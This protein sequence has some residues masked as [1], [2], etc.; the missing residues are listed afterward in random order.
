M[1]NPLWPSPK[2][3]MEKVLEDL[4]KATTIIPEYESPPVFPQDYVL[5]PS[6][7]YAIAKRTMQCLA[8]PNKSGWR[9]S[10]FNLARQGLEMPHPTMFVHHYK[11]VWDASQGKS[12]ICSAEEHRPLNIYEV[13]EIW[14]YLAE[15][16]DI[17]IWLNFLCEGVKD[18]LFRY[19]YITEKGNVRG[20]T[21]RLAYKYPQEP[22]FVE[23]EFTKEGLPVRR[24]PTEIYLPGENV[25]YEPP[26]IN[27]AMHF[28]NDGS[29]PI[30]SFIEK[31]KLLDVI[32][33]RRVN[34]D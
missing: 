31:G 12:K 14:A 22:G 33:C 2:K 7:K 29:N 21:E 10:I 15:N 9:D 20:I 8:A 3:G 27:T 26:S 6:G 18:P 24:A 4:I 28:H 25:L 5:D 1:T 34:H 16:P 17:N 23:L 11:N 32:P 19:Y 30:I 13:K